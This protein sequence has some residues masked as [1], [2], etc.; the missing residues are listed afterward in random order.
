[1]EPCILAG[2]PEGGIVLDPFLGS[3]TTATVARKLGRG[4]IGIE[5]NPEY[6]RMAEGRIAEVL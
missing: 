5:I 3:G 6:C 2:C 4:C 1:M